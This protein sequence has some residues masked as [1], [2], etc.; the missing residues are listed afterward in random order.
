[1]NSDILISHQYIHGWYCAIVNQKKLY[2]CV[3][4][5][6]GHRL[7]I[8]IDCEASVRGYY[9]A[10]TVN[11]TTL[12][13]QMSAISATSQATNAHTRD[14]TTGFKFF[15]YIFFYNIYLFHKRVSSF[16]RLV[17]SFRLPEGVLVNTNQFTTL[18]IFVFTVP[19]QS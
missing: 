15:L 5:S 6:D 11:L 8:S 12:K 2:M 3:S 16:F 13:N 10:L 14:N 18:N 17:S 1:M 19:K 9:T 4:L 7:K